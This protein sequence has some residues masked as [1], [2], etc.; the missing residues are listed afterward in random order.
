MQEEG[1]NFAPVVIPLVAL[2]IGWVLGFFD[3]NNRTKKKIKQAED[4]AEVAIKK[5]E[6][7]VAELKA[8]IADSPTTPYSMDDP[9]LMRVKNENGRL[10]LELDGEQMIPNAL[11]TEQRKRLIE[12]LNAMRPWLDGKP[13]ITPAH[14]KPLSI[15]PAT[16]APIQEKPVSTSTE[17]PSVQLEQVS[18]SK[19]KGKASSKKKDEEPEAPPTSIVGQINIILQ[20]QIANTPLASR[21]LSLME[22]ASGG[23]NVYLGTNRYEGVD[24]V[25]DE[26]VK[27]AIRTAIAAWEKKYTPGMPQQ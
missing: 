10:T 1:W 26:D 8:K 15:K 27:D 25:P 11:T 21:G 17:S 12:M 16:L 4:S 24:D 5:A 18:A 9:G 22:S 19:S 14:V 23:V 20:E 2:L 7:K 6:D 3:S 13:A